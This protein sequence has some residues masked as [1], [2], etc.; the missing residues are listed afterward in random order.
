LK[1][2]ISD[3]N[4]KLSELYEKAGNTG[5]SLK[6]YKNHI[7]FRDSVNNIRSVQ[8]MADLRTDYEIAQKQVEVDLLNQEKRNQHII[9]LS[10][11]IILGLASIILVTL[12]WFYRIISKEKKQEA[13]PAPVPGLSVAAR[14]PLSLSPFFTPC[15]KSISSYSCPC[16]L[17]NVS[18]AS[19]THLAAWSASM[20]CGRSHV[21]DAASRPSTMAI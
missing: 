8:K 12:Y 10:L 7:V 4:L 13:P 14:Y 20:D 6:Y 9:V 16:S 11:L 15:K 2:Q 1:E 18:T 3:A 17:F 5:E 19:S 21:T